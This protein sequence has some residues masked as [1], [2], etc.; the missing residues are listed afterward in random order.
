MNP[1]MRLDAFY[2]EIRWELLKASSFSIVSMRKAWQRE[3]LLKCWDNC[4]ISIATIERCKV[5]TL[6]SVSNVWTLNFSLVVCRLMLTQFLSVGLYRESKLQ[7][8]RLP[9]VPPLKKKN[10]SISTHNKNKKNKNKEENCSIL[11]VS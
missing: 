10:I 11:R 5:V 8:K 1:S 4:V 7:R 3:I 9:L 6:Q 2:R